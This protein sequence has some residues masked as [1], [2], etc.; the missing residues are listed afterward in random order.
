MTDKLQSEAVAERPSPRSPN[1]KRRAGTQCPEAVA[2]RP[3]EAQRRA[4]TQYRKGWTQALNVKGQVL[5]HQMLD[6]GSSPEHIAAMLRIQSKQDISLAAITRYASGYRQR[7][8]AERQ[9]RARVDAFVAQAREQGITISDLLRG[10]LVAKLSSA[11]ADPKI[12]K[13]DLF[14]LEAAERQRNTLD[15]RREQFVVTVAHRE[16]EMDLKERHAAITAERFALDQRKAQAVLAT[17]EHKAGRGRQIT[18]N[19]LRC[20]REIYG[21][22]TVE[23]ETND[24]R[25]QSAK[26][27]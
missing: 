7:R 21:L 6:Q 17:L 18:L 16:R 24:E 10:A 2:K 8:Q 12:D 19:D 11:P 1:A 14:K 20:I 22:S 26:A 23:T 13:L 5:L 3:T 4:G 15:L 9:M 27:N 25:S